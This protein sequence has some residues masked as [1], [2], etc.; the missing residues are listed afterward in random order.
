MADA[1]QLAVTIVAVA[2]GLFL[3]TIVPYL[4]KHAQDGTVTFDQKYG[5]WAVVVFVSSLF[6]ALT[7]VDSLPDLVQGSLGA[8][9]LAYLLLTVTTNHVVFESI[10]KGK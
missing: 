10:D 2:L 5:L 3:R 9:F 1:A 4:N 7:T 6:T 8:T